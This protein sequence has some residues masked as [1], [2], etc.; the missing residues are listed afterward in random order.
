MSNILM[1]A[2]PVAIAVIV[3]A[4]LLLTGYVKA[5]PDEAAV[6]SGL[7]KQPR[8]L[9][10]K[11]GF[12]IPYFEK[13]DRIYI[14]SI[15][16]YIKT[17][18]YIPT[19]DFIN[20]TVD[21]VAQV[22]VDTS[23]VG[24]QRAIRNFLNQKKESIRDMLEESLQGNLR[25][26]IGT[27]D[28]KSICQDKTRFSNEV[29]A[30][31]EGDMAELGIKI[32]AFNVKNIED[33]QNLIQD[34]GIDNIEQI[35]KA[36]QIAKANAE[37]EVAIERAKAENDA[38][39]EKI[40]ADTAIAQ[41]NNEYQITV[42][43]L[44][45]TEDT[46]RAE[47]DAAYEIENQSQRKT[48]S[49]KEQEADIARR[50]K[51]IELQAKEAEVAEKRLIAE[52]QKPAE[53]HKYAAIQEADA[54]LYKRQKDADAKLYEEQKEADAIS[55]R[56]KAEADAIRMKGEAEAE[57]MDKKAE[58]M[59]KY[60]QAAIL[61]MIVGVLPDI[62]KA[63][64]EPI[65][66]ISEVKIIGSDSKGVSDIGG[67]VPLM[68]A[69]VMESVKETTGVDMTEIVKANTYDAKV[70]RH[71]TIDGAVPVQTETPD[72][73]TAAESDTDSEA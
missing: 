26:I 17:S 55:A 15:T 24:I 50:E 31:A 19:S 60:G 40:K 32:L 46:K 11:G 29:K 51:E 44:K 21:A 27:M 18:D 8:I 28:L 42:A 71:V 54:D 45:V 69:K 37:K 59:K 67:N 61:E 62:A 14:G 2:V 13:V 73:E 4:I 52:V 53:A 33:D 70:N 34:L 35:R 38:N 10:G 47:A 43:N 63:V 3:L 23:D 36:A 39:A 6:I 64:A 65:S 68:L 16:T 30:N 56:G 20:I 66:S 49:I 7:S 1:I 9:I 48:I 5:S 25:E 58:A 57:A 41:R 72:A 22:S 12:K